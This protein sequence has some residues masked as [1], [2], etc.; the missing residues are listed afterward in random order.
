MI[1]KS[2]THIDQ[3]T[4]WN[5][6]KNDKLEMFERERQWLKVKEERIYQRWAKKKQSKRRKWRDE[7]REE[8]KFNVLKFTSVSC[9]NV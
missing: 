9:S 5:E 3:N 1:A 2:S 6:E 4:R 7:W 8:R